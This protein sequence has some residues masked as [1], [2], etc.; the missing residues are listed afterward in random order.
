MST[1]GT[2]IKLLFHLCNGITF[3]VTVIFDSH[4]EGKTV[5]LFVIRQFLCFIYEISK[6]CFFVFSRCWQH[7]NIISWLAHNKFLQ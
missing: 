4:S 3:F 5:V 2:R 6:A 7:S 1:N